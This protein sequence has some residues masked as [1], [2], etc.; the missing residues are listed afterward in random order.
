MQL[1]CMQLDG[2]LVKFLQSACKTIG[3]KALT[4]HSTPGAACQ[5]F[6]NDYTKAV[7]SPALWAAPR[8]RADH[9]SDGATPCLLQPLVCRKGI[10]P[11]NPLFSWEHPTHTR[12]HTQ[13]HAHTV[14][15]EQVGQVSEGRTQNANCCLVPPTSCHYGGSFFLQS[16]AS[17]ENTE[18]DS[19]RGMTH[20][21]VRSCSWC[22]SATCSV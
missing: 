3:D 11:T 21:A 14:A 7:P 22:C 5:R 4:E 1:S 2:S 15:Q 20:S 10:I 12:T 18:T 8:L 17:N 16:T 9:V 6:K 19:R 13:R